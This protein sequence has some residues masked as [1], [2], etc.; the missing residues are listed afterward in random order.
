MEARPGARRE[1][2]PYPRPHAPEGPRSRPHRVRPLAV[3]LLPPQP[4]GVVSVPPAFL[5]DPEPRRVP[6]PVARRLPAESPPAL[7]GD[8][9]RAR[10]ADLRRAPVVGAVDG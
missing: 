10:L 6:L 7:A 4:A 1:G 2:R 5:S 8:R 3:P 9:R